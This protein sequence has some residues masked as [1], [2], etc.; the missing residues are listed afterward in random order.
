MRGQT[1]RTLEIKTHSQD[2]TKGLTYAQ[3]IRD[4]VILSIFV[5]EV[6]Q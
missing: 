5:D 3:Q 4:P 6:I 1:I 2:L